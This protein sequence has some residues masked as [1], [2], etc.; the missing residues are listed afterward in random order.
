MKTMPGNEKHATV[1]KK[2]PF[3]IMKDQEKHENQA[4]VGK[5]NK[6]YAPVGQNA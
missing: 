2:I 3:G 4:D 1:S 5:L 6:K